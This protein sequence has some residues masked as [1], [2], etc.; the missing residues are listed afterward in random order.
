MPLW[1]ID[2]LGSRV[3]GGDLPWHYDRAGTVI[4]ASPRHELRSVWADTGVRE[5]VAEDAT[6]ADFGPVGAWKGEREVG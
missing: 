1:K 5:V 6:Q 2:H 3:S 4:E